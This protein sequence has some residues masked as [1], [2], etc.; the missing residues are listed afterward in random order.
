MTR[1]SLAL[2]GPLQITVDGTQLAAFAYNKVLALLAYLAIEADR[3]HRREALAGLLWPDQDEPAARHSLS[4]AIWSVSRSL[5]SDS[6]PQPV[7]LRTRET[8]QLNPAGEHWLDV[9]EFMRLIASCE[10]HLHLRDDCAQCARRLERAVDLYRGRLLE[11]FSIADSPAFEEWLLVKREQFHQQ[12]LQALI[13]LTSFHERRGHYAAALDAARRLVELEPWREEGHRMVMRLLAASGQ[14]VAALKQY[15][16][17]R[18]ILADELG[19]EP[20]QETT[21]LYHQIR[22]GESGRPQSIDVVFPAQRSLNI[23]PVPT[24]A[25]VGRERE[26]AE[27]SAL[28]HDPNCRLV[29]LVG[30]GGTGKTRLAIQVAAEVSDEFAHGVCFVPF[31]ALGALDTSKW[32]VQSIAEALSFTFHDQDDPLEQLIGYLRERELLLVLDNF[33]QLLY[34]APVVSALLE[35]APELRVIVTSR[36]RLNLHAEWV[37]PVEG[38][39][40][41]PPDELDRIE[42]YSAVQLFLHSARRASPHYELL[43]QDRQPVARLCS[44]VEGLPLAIELAASWVPALTCAEIAAEIERSLDFLATAYRDG[45]A[46]HQSMRAVFD[47]SW[48]ML[49]DDERAVFRR[50]SVFRQGF[51]P[52]ASERVVG[53]SLPALAT[54]V[55][56]SL[57]RSSGSGRFEIHELLR[58]YAEDKLAD[59][60]EEERQTRDRHAAYFAD[61]LSTRGEHLRGHEQD[62]A[63]AELSKEIENVRAAWF[64]ASERARTD[65]IAKSADC[66]WL[67][68]EMTGR[69]EEGEDAFGRAVAALEAAHAPDRADTRLFSLALGRSLLGQA[70]LLIR[71]GNN[72]RARQFLERCIKLFRAAD[73]QRDLGLALNVLAVIAHALRDY[74]EEQHLLR[75]SLVLFAAAGDR[76]GLAYSLNDLGM[77]TGLLG[78]HSEASH[79]HQESLTI[80]SQLGD[81]RGMAF[82]LNNLGVVAALDG[83]YMAARQFHERSLAIRQSI[84]NHWGIAYSLSQI[85]TVA[86]VVGDDDQ[87]RAYLLDALRAAMDI[88]ALPIVLKVLVEMAAL[89]NCHGQRQQ[90]ADILSL[91]AHHSA[92]DGDTRNEADQLLAE[93]DVGHPAALSLKLDLRDGTD[94]LD[95]LVQ[96]LLQPAPAPSAG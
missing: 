67:F 36:E 71:L 56:K 81:K 43:P 63:L 45:P 5:D 32:L 15:E 83:D 22:R 35:R 50:L 96:A 75:E 93:L 82:A 16:R 1:L 94:A 23:L 27:I 58:Q 68:Y 41:P 14:R 20:E 90:A 12:A 70:A 3:P 53:A 79:L 52:V 66:L 77:V 28:L 84:G 42:A 11:Q 86:R 61:L 60:P 59:D 33:E 87:A 39:S 91:V 47:H 54:L 69:Y 6:A 80:S 65:D 51:R 62:A 37:Y 72:D 7:L 57:L 13:R 38:L 18:V 88:R 44:L 29:T 92:S 85:G 73:A 95:D 26:R 24:T 17:C 48:H 40:L 49:S 19:L 74:R 31:G 30:P 55:S 21:E 8:V 78:K 2:F 9:A 89:L 64:W 34:G 10:R 25:F 76:W 46:R 4:Q